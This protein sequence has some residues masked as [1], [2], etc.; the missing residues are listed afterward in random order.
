MRL[1]R[2][3]GLCRPA[4]R[5]GGCALPSGPRRL[6]VCARL[7]GRRRRCL[8]PGAASFFVHDV[9]PSA[10]AARARVGR[11]RPQG[12][13]PLHLD[14]TSVSPFSARVRGFAPAHPARHPARVRLRARLR[15]RAA[16]VVCCI[17]I[18]PRCSCHRRALSSPIPDNH[19]H[20]LFGS[21][22]STAAVAARWTRPWAPGVARARHR[23][24]RRL[25][26]RRPCFPATRTQAPTP[27]PLWSPAPV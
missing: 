18:Q 5:P 13:A 11:A 2:D 26:Q 22:L 15:R 1:R 10:R 27:K 4:H 3:P 25:V 12:S 19:P 6:G 24:A 14:G 17:S 7:S 21:L 9:D 16:R 20:L 8:E 23:S